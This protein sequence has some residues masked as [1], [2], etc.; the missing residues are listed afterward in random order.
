MR[1]K[2]IR[3]E[4]FEVLLVLIPNYKYGK[5]G[6]T[7]IQIAAVYFNAVAREPARKIAIRSHPRI[8]RVIIIPL[9]VIC[10]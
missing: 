5:M 8:R 3:N 9:F 1:P 7:G 4:G 10:L 6:W 2:I